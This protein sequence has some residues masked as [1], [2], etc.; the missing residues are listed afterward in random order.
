VRADVLLPQQHQRHTFAPQFLAYA[1]VVGCNEAAGALLGAQQAAVQ[2]SFIHNLD[3]CPVRLGRD[4]QAG[5]LGYD[6]LGEVQ[7]G[8]DALVREVGLEFET[9][10]VFDLAHSDPSGIGH[11]GSGKKPGRPPVS[12]GEYA[13]H[14]TLRLDTVPAS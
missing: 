1:G 8:G 9:Q 11:A 13:Q 5:V 4:G 6:A 14:H 7:G 3:L 12:V 10:N 2:G